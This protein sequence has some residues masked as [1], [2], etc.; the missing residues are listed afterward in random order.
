MTPATLPVTKPAA[1]MKCVRK[2]EYR[3]I[4]NSNMKKQELEEKLVMF[5]RGRSRPAFISW[6]E[7]GEGKNDGVAYLKEHQ[8]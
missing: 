8:S 3:A 6:L 2:A 7:F 4:E 5:N 1:P